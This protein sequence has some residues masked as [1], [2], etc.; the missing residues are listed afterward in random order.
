MNY[1]S[2][3]FPGRRRPLER[4]MSA[5]SGWFWRVQ[6]LI[7]SSTH[8]RIWSPSYLSTGMND[9]TSIARAVAILCGA[10]VPFAIMHWHIGL[11]DA[12]FTMCG[13]GP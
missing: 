4:W 13:W 12:I 9:L 10:G 6:Q 3:L 7:R 2:T 8:R 11:P 1:L 5:H